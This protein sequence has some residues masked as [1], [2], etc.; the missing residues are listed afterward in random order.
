MGDGSW[1]EHL[2]GIHQQ[3]TVGVAQYLSARWRWMSPRVQSLELQ[4]EEEEKE[5]R[6][7][8]SNL[9]LQACALVHELPSAMLG[10]RYQPCSQACGH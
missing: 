3:E 9:S 1:V 5:L 6:R 2:H 4:K 10:P 7:G 8:K